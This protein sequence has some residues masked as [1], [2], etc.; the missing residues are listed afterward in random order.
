[1]HAK[2]LV[3][4]TMQE[5][6]TVFFNMALTVLEMTGTPITGLLRFFPDMLIFFL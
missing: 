4:K 3:L 6:E 2:K 5:M 1:M